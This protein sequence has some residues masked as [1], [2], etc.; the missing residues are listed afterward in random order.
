MPSLSQM[1]GNLIDLIKTSGR[2]RAGSAKESQAKRAR[3]GQNT[4]EHLPLP[5]PHQL[6][7][8]QPAHPSQHQGEEAQE[9]QDHDEVEEVP[10]AQLN[11]PQNPEASRIV[12]NGGHATRRTID[13]D[14][15]Q[16]NERVRQAMPAAQAY[17]EGQNH[18]REVV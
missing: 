1:I 9:Q 3:H 13:H 17:W 16:Q 10:L 14:A 15:R 4:S 18:A 8:T 12:S 5:L 7:R 6:Q 11:L 2:K